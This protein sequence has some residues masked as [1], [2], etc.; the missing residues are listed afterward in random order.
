LAGRQPRI[1]LGSAAV[2]AH[3]TGADELLQMP[4]TEIGIV[5]MEPPIEAHSSLVRLHG[6]GFDVWHLFG[7]AVAAS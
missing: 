3:L 5:D 2:D 1:G 7:R 6:S 4:E